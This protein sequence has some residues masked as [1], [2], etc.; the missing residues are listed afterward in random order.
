[1]PTVPPAPALRAE[2]L[3]ERFPADVALR[4]GL[5]GGE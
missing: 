5:T 1:M 2:H 4:P 3:T